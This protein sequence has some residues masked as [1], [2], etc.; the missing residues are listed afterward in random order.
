MEE[1]RRWPGTGR[2]GEP[3]SDLALAHYKV[4]V[5]VTSGPACRL[6]SLLPTDRHCA[7]RFVSKKYAPSLSL[8]LSLRFTEDSSSI[9]NVSLYFSVS[10]SFTVD[11]SLI[12]TSLS[13]YMSFSHLVDSSLISTS[14]S[15]SLSLSLIY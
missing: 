15:L 12:S 11:R 13:L 6:G 9:S 2:R 1:K 10:L 7:K 4:R 5:A 3:G 8:S 14:L